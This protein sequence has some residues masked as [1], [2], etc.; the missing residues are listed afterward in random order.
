M[1]NEPNAGSGSALMPDG[2]RSGLRLVPREEEK[3]AAPNPLAWTTEPPLSRGN[4]L[5]RFLH[6]ESSSA[7]LL[8]AAVLGA[9]AWASI[10]PWSYGWFWET[11]I[12][13]ALGSWEG[14]VTLREVVDQGLMTIFFLV[15]GLEARREL[16]LGELR[17]R[18]RLVLPVVVGATGILLPVAIYLAVTGLADAAATSGWAVAM[19]TDT[20][21]SLGTLTVLGRNMP[22]STRTFLLTALVVDDIVALVVIA[23]GYSE[24]VGGLPLLVAAGSAAV[25]WVSGRLPHGQRQ[26][27]LVV[28][29]VTLWASLLLAH[30]DPVIA[31]LLIGV[32][33]SAHT[34]HRSSL[35]E[36]TSVV[37]QFREQPGPGLARTAQLQ[38]AASLSAN[39][40]LQYLFHPLASRVIVPVFALG[41]A[42]VRLTGE[43]VAHA[44]GSPITIGIVLAYLLGKPL[45]AVSASWATERA[46]AGAVRPQVGYGAVL[47]GGVVAGVGLTVSLLIAGLAFDG[48]ALNDAKL[49]ILA[50]MVTAIGASSITFKGIGAL[51]E[52]VRLRAMHGRGE[53]LQDLTDPVDDDL[54]HIRGERDALVTVV[55]YGD[56]E[57]RWT[58]MASPTAAE[59][60]ARNPDIR[61]V[62]RH[63]PLSDVHRDAEVAAQAAEAA[64]AQGRFWQMHAMLLE[65][66][67]ALDAPSL[68]IYASALGLD[69]DR[70]REDLEQRRHAMRVARDIESADASGVA[71]TPT[72]VI[73]GRRHEGPADLGTLTAGIEVAR[74]RARAALLA[75]GG[76]GWAAGARRR[77]PTQPMRRKNGA[78]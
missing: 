23:A 36:A 58:A 1:K 15:V 51:P 42:G 67:D 11:P 71:G 3:P 8:L 29:G 24:G 34:P 30:L 38:L 12:R 74:A 32:A 59:L 63:L 69:V 43:S 10:A 31:G 65:H 35:E 72:F 2:R 17:D 48:P 61:Y 5:R 70:F 52:S 53:D 18:R 45:A 75:S 28:F 64:G 66:Q 73:N 14:A 33:T 47:G 27:A 56:F 16:D 7:G 41:N 4:P 60:L 44:A 22:A 25:I 55:E 46:T 77:R 50:T 76:A 57:C 13:F 78:A 20:A 21:L 54:D 62:W 40:R 19:S 68:M 9:L 39:T 49:G 37:R 6:T 26:A